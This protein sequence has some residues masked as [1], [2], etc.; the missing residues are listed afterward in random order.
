[1]SLLTEIKQAAVDESVPVTVLLRK[2]M[3]LADSL[4][5]EDLAQWAGR[6]LNGYPVDVPLPDYRVIA[7]PAVGSFTNGYTYYPELGISPSALPEDSR[8]FGRQVFLR[9]PI[10]ELQSLAATDQKGGSITCP[11]PAGLINRLRND[12]YRGLQL[13]SASQ[14][15]GH[16]PLIGVMD[17]V[18]NRV[19]EFAIAL[20]KAY[21]D[22]GEKSSAPIP[23][24]FVTQVFHTTI[25]GRVTNLAVGGGTVVQMAVTVPPGDE[26]ALREALSRLG[27]PQSELDKLELD[28][29]PVS[30]EELGPK[31]TN[32]I[33]SIAA[34][35]GAGTLAL[36]KGVG[37]NLLVKAILAYYGMLVDPPELPPLPPPP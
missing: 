3:L 12:L 30:A 16:A 1:M 10:S 19:L 32:W 36:A 20:Q 8:D 18:R 35:V 28:E 14:Q 37:V 25:Y 33:G 15:V 2:C 4:G 11:W 5:N 17:A 7:A 34:K 27:V 22:A 26:K 21:P 29:K 6:E 9:H 24:G 13:I 31:A 23:E